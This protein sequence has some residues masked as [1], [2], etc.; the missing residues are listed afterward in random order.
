MKFG[1]WLQNKLRKTGFAVN[2]DSSSS[3]PFPG[4]TIASKGTFQGLVSREPALIF[5]TWTMYICEKSRCWRLLTAQQVHQEA[6]FS[7]KSVQC[8]ERRHSCMGTMPPPAPLQSGNM[9][10]GSASRVTDP[11]ATPSVARQGGL[12]DGGHQDEQPAAQSWSCTV[13]RAPL[14]ACWSSQLFQNWHRCSL[15][16]KA[17]CGQLDLS[18]YALLSLSHPVL[19]DISESESLYNLFMLAHHHAA[20]L[21]LS[22]SFH[23]PFFPNLSISRA[24]K[25]PYSCPHSS[26]LTSNSFLIWIL[27]SP[28]ETTSSWLKPNLLNVKY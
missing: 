2:K 21:R 17:S 25:H 12:E 3:F 20:A 24:P 14:A 22:K 26:N 9:L 4:T 18:I 11:S 13:G 10:Q 5:A 27:L 8:K 15:E 1:F 28:E 6:F 19:L 7:S 16:V 23:P